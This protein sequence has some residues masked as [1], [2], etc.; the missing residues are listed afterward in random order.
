MH[1]AKHQRLRFVRAQPFGARPLLNERF[2]SDVAP[3]ETRSNG[4]HDA[5]AIEH[6]TIASDL[7]LDRDTMPPAIVSRFAYVTPPGEHR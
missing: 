5:P 1:R 3:A 6:R 7:A 2:P 4:G